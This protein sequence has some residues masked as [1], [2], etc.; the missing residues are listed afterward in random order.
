MAGFTFQTLAS[1]ATNGPL[2]TSLTPTQAAQLVF[3]ASTFN[4]AA[5]DQLASSLANQDMQHV[6]ADEPEGT[7]NQLTIDGWNGQATAAAN[8]VNA[9]WQAGHVTGPGGHPTTPWPDAGYNQQLAWAT[10]SGDTLVLRWT[11]EQP[12]AYILVGILVV[13]VGY[14]VY[15]V[16]T[17]SSWSLSSATPGTATGPTET[18]PIIG[19]Q[20]GGPFRVLWLPW[21]D[22]AAIAA[23]AVLVPL[24]YHQI[25][26]VEGLR[27][28][29]LTDRARIRRIRSGEGT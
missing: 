21:Y 14:L 11:K 13:V 12:M 7:R 1:S 8:A 5:F 27:V 24:G 22:T 2:L 16:L 25:V 10:G 3:Y 26:E 15:R 29:D 19:A 6:E 17:S 28:Q 9:A 20:P 18:V 23:A 4:T